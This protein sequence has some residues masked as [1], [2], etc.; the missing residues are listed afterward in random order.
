MWTLANVEPGLE[1]LSMAIFT[2]ALGWSKE[3]TE[4]FLA[5]VRKDL[6]NTKMHSYWEMYARKLY[7]GLMLTQEQIQCH[8]TKAIVNLVTPAGTLLMRAC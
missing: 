5:D 8:W 7:F 6:K 3:E 2:R 1:G 4:V